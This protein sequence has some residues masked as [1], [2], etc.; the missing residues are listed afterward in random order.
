MK[1]FPFWERESV[2]TPDYPAGQIM[3]TTDN[4]SVSFYFLFK[5]KCMRTCGRI[6]ALLNLPDFIFKSQTFSPL[7]KIMPGW[8]TP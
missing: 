2:V 6:S 3:S 4:S 5:L 7:L 8:L 1:I